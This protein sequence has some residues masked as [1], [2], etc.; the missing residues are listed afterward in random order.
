MRKS[1]VIIVALLTCFLVL[2]C[3]GGDN[4]KELSDRRDATVSVSPDESNN[5]RNS[6]GLIDPLDGVWVYPAEQTGET[7]ITVIHGMSYKNYRY[8]AERIDAKADLE[9]EGPVWG[10]EG[11]YFFPNKA[12]Y[13][14]PSFF[15][16]SNGQKFLLLN[17]FDYDKFLKRGTVPV[18]LQ[19]RVGDTLDVAK[20]PSRPSI[21][22]LG[23]PCEVVLPKKHKAVESGN[24]G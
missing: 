19:I 12:N 16:K 8:S 14:S 5:E 3:C 13:Y 20:P 9:R 10:Q 6:S 24:K 7:T 4:S 21:E 1:A 22:I 17:R 2:G 23:L 18:Q 11:V 15:Q